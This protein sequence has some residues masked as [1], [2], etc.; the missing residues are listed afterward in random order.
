MRPTVLLALGI[1]GGVLLAMPQPAKTQSLI[2]QDAHDCH[3]AIYTTMESYDK[4]EGKEKVYRHYWDG[5][6]KLG[7]ATGVF[8]YNTDQRP[9]YLLRKSKMQREL[10]RPELAKLA[11]TCISA[12]KHNNSKSINPFAARL[13]TADFIATRAKI[14][15]LEAE[16][17]Q[18]RRAQ[19]Q[20]YSSPPQQS[21]AP[22]PQIDPKEAECRG[23]MDAGVARATKDMMAARKWVE[24]WIKMGGG[25]ALGGDYVQSG[26]NTINST[27]NRLNAAQCHPDYANALVKFRRDYYIGLP[28]G[29][30]FQCG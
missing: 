14:A 24:A 5:L 9:I 27:I 2:Q 30:M 8:T 10:T 26:C 22:A 28:N 17:E 3:I 13:N 20:S 25:S 19:S 18:Q 12:L 7:N 4:V 29:G 21:R 23:I 15:E 11:D 16:A 6:T 1:A